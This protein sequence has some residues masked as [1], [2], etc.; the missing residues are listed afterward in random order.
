MTEKNIKEVLS[1][2]F[3]STSM[4]PIS[5]L[6]AAYG[7]WSDMGG[8][9]YTTVAAVAD[10]KHQQNFLEELD[11]KMKD[12]QLYVQYSA[13]GKTP[14]V[15]PF[16]CEETGTKVMPNQNGYVKLTNKAA[17][18]EEDRLEDLKLEKLSKMI[19]R[20]QKSDLRACET[21]DITEQMYKY[22]LR[23]IDDG[24]DKGYQTDVLKFSPE[25]CKVNG[26]LTYIRG[27]PVQSKE[28]MQ[29]EQKFALVC[30][31]RLDFY[32][33]ADFGVRLDSQSIQAHTS[34]APDGARDVYGKYVQE[35]R[36]MASAG[37]NRIA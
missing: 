27:L 24:G 32:N 23:P 6:R 21:M 35:G 26:T 34:E 12:R 7:N 9:K 30:E 31:S 33:L 20:A 1:K 17:V 3:D 37:I 19:K 13:D 5:Q 10:R 14:I 28:R 15:E 22:M 18:D 8:R 36:N 29:A 25:L 2:G 4:A 11:N 16:Y